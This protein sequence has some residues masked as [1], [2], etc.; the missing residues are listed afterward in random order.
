MAWTKKERPSPQYISLKVSQTWGGIRRFPIW[1]RSLLMWPSDIKKIEWI[2]KN[3]P[4][5][6]CQIGLQSQ[7]ASDRHVPLAGFTRP[8][9]AGV[10]KWSLEPPACVTLREWV[11]RQTAGAAEHMQREGEREQEAKR[12]ERESKRETAHSCPPPSLSR[13]PSALWP[14]ALPFSTLQAPSRWP[15]R[16]QIPGLRPKYQNSKY[17]QIAGRIAHRFTHLAPHLLT[18]MPPLTG[19]TTHL[20]SFKLNPRK[21]PKLSYPSRFPIY[22]PSIYTYLPHLFF[23]SFP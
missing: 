14:P 1:H 22:P 18:K 8:G 3:S 5:N 2:L 4:L 15:P 11:G 19:P 9:W 10:Q 16:M 23:F 20:V 21:S 7:S 17:V 13:R 12:R 6:L